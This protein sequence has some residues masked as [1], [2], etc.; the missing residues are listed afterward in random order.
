MMTVIIRIIKII[1]I[2]IIKILIIIINRLTTAAV[3]KKGY[4]PNGFG[5]SF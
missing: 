2:M 1:K 5:S 4:D 3:N